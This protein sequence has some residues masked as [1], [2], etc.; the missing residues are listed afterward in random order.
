M[1][2]N[3]GET[4]TDVIHDIILAHGRDVSPGFLGT[5]LQDSGNNVHRANFEQPKRWRTRLK[6]SVKCCIWSCIMAQRDGGVQLSN[7][8]IFDEHPVLFT[9]PSFGS[10]ERS[11]QDR[12]P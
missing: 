12:L 3:C 2:E 10:G 5:F 4:T 6:L 9:L 1:Q 8:I 7:L 11:T